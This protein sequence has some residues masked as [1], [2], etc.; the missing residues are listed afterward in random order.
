MSISPSAPLIPGLAQA[1]V[2]FVIPRVGV[3]LP[4]GIDPFLLFKSRDSELSQLHSIILQTF[5][6]GIALIRSGKLSDVRQLFDFPEASEVGFGY[7]QKS[8][9][10]AGVG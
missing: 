5:N 4:M 9:R 3:D 10:G 1:E 7:T 6:E 8:K 2:D